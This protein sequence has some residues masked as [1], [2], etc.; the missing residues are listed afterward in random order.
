MESPFLYRLEI[1]LLDGEE[2]IDGHGASFGMCRFVIQDGDYLLNGGW[3]LVR[4]P[5]FEGL[6]PTGLAAPPDEAFVRHELQPAKDAGLNLIRLWRKPQPPIVYDVADEIGL[7]FVGTM[8]IE[9]MSRWLTMTPYAERRIRNEVRESV[10]RDRNHPCIV[11]WE[12]FNEITRSA[13]QR[14]KQRV[15]R[16]ARKLDLSRF[17]LDESGGFGGGAFIYPPNSTEP[18]QINNV[19]A[20]GVAAREKQPRD[21]QVGGKRAVIGADSAYVKVQGESVGVQVVVDD[22]S[23]QIY[24]AGHRY[25]R[26]LR[27]D[28]RGDKALVCKSRLKCW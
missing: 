1:D 7:L 8:P 24:G 19:Q 21:V 11:S 6:Y 10:R 5:F 13:L 17:I 27:R 12:I 28:N 25:Q 18:V 26:E 20:A 14:I 22:E 9:C 15:S 2:T 4:S 3:L 23:G 16:E